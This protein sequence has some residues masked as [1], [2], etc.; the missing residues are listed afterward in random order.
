M[1]ELEDKG[2]L[3]YYGQCLNSCDNEKLSSTND[4]NEKFGTERHRF[5]Y[6]PEKICHIKC[7]Y[8]EVYDISDTDKSTPINIISKGNCIKSCSEGGSYNFESEDGK[9]CLNGCPDNEFYYT[10]S[11]DFGDYNKCVSSCKSIGK[12]YINNNNNNDNVCY[13]KCDFFLGLGLFLVQRKLC[14][15]FIKS[16]KLGNVFM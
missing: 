16:I 13:W 11:D 1:Y 6:T 8:K 2:K 5:Y 3:K 12:F 14:W 7:P 4:D 10:Y 15:I 9:Y